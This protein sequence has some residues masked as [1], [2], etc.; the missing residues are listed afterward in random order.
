M[1]ISITI[2]NPTDAILRALLSSGAD[3]SVTT[4]AS[5]PVT[6]TI[7]ADEDHTDGQDHGAS[8]QTQTAQPADDA[9][10]KLIATL[11]GSYKRAKTVTLKGGAQGKEGDE[12]TTEDGTIGV[13]EAV[14]RGRAI[15]LFDD[16]TAE[17]L[18]SSTLT[19]VTEDD[20]TPA[21]TQTAAPEQAEATASSRRRR[22][23]AAEPEVDPTIA[24]KHPE[25][26]EAMRI[27]HA[28]DKGVLDSILKEFQMASLDEFKDLEGEDLEDFIQIILETRSS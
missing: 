2:T 4:A 26:A 22:G 28:L 13:L 15:V 3:V 27:A 23:A 24:Q 7:P 9:V 19:L 17:E 16:G 14:Y 8:S 20:K 6:S 18:G 25:A 1:N 21:Q 5:A 12:V 10:A 11:D